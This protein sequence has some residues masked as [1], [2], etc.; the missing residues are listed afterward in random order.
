MEPEDKRLDRLL[1]YT[2][3]HI[4]IYLS[5][6][7]GI[8]ALLGSNEHVYVQQ[9]IGSPKALLGGL[10]FMAIA[11]LAGGIIASSCAQYSGY[12][13]FW[14]KPQGP[15]L[16]KLWIGRTWAFIEHTSFWI[17]LALIVYAVLRSPTVW[18]WLCK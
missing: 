10:I 6:G 7:G 18:T 16:L 5:I 8:V 13:E 12:D 15:Y 14:L 4:G 11:G 3:F 9:L 2:K 17:G 1:E